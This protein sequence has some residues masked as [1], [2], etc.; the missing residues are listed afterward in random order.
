MREETDDSYQPRLERAARTLAAGG[1]IAYPTEAVYGLGCLPDE[2][3]AVERLLRIKRRSW[4]KGLILIAADIAQLEPLIVLPEGRLREE[5]LASWPGPVTWLLPARRGVPAF[6][7][8]GRRTLAVRVTAHPLARQLCTRLAGPIVSTSANRSGRRPLKRAL[9]VRREL[10]R[11]LDDLLVGP[12]GSL[13]RPTTLRDGQTG[14]T[15]R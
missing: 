3:R 15:L 5:I 8:G 14:R 4:R 9:H 11:E 7:S 2:R 10:G 6:L 1:L 13:Q 12:L